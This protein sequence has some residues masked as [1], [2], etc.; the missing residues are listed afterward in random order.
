[1]SENFINQFVDEVKLKYY[2]FIIYV[3][4]IDDEPILFIIKDEIFIEI[5]LINFIK[6]KPSFP[7]NE[8]DIIIIDIQKIFSKF[9]RDYVLSN[10]CA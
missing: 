9:K 3:D 6:Y 5:E 10:I 1:M 4:I 7:Y 8:D 2:D